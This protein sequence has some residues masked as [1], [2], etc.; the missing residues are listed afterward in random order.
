MRRIPPILAL[1]VLL[2]IA[3]PAGAAS[4]T[5]VVNEIDYDQPGTDTAEFVELHNVSGAPVELGGHQLRL[6]N[7]NGGATYVTVDLPAGALEPGGHY[8]VCANAATVAGCDLDIAPDTNLVQN[9]D[10]DAVSLW[11]GAALVDAVSYGGVVPGHVEGP[12]GAPK[13]S[14]VAGESLARVPDGCD[15]DD[16]AAD[17]AVAP[18]TPGAS[19]G[20]PAC[21]G[22]RPVTPHP[23]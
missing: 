3:A 1:L 11:N 14:A 7:G 17:F 16:N 13:D 8:V 22:V 4:S 5:L 9:G 6:V 21:A 10:P 15:T 20:E 19:N 23:P 18:A 2:L 12:A